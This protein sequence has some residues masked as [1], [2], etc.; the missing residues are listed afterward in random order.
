M[1]MLSPAVQAN[2]AAGGFARLPESQVR[3]PPEL[4][5]LAWHGEVRDGACLCLSLPLCCHLPTTPKSASLGELLA[6]ALYLVQ[7]CLHM[8]QSSGWVI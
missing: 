7:R 3:P 6:R 5:D 8:T 4:P 1:F 2:L